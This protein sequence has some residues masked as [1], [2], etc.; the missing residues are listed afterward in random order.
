MEG[1][2]R[3]GDGERECNRGR[4]EVSRREGDEA[5]ADCQEAVI[6]GLSADRRR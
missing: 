2:E 6:V 1:D 4:V 5:A 3:K